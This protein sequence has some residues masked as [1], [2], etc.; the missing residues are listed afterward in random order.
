[1]NGRPRMSRRIVILGA[2][3][4]IGHKLYEV[5]KPRFKT[6]IPVLHSSRERFKQSGLFEGSDTIEHVDV[7]DF[8]HTAGVLHA[9]RPDIVLSCAGITKRRPEVEDAVT[10]I[11]VNSLFPQKLAIWAKANDAR[12]IHF[13]TDCVF[14]GKKA[15][16]EPPYNEDS[17]TNGEDAYG[18]TKALGEIRDDHNLTIRSSFI[19]REL[20]VHSEL[21]DWFLAQEGHSIKGFT[22]AMY[23][24]VTT[25]VMARIVGDIIEHHPSLA[26]LWQLGNPVPIN[27]YDLLCKAREAFGID[28][29]ISPDD[30]P[31]PNAILDGA[32][33]HDQI[34]PDIPS[35]DE[36]LN[37]LAKDTSC[38]TNIKLG[39]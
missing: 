28:V 4:L 20:S 12:V 23:S 31:A 16:A 15:S 1:M 5:L 21:I 34:N 39:A 26:G 38:Y 14:N 35:W 6:V 9:L 27:K 17:P 33:L 37:E 10:A 3:G 29:E 30:R 11:T 36:M 24:G 32:K 25:P 18:R 22:N 19:G 7:C 8:E 2:S 13:S